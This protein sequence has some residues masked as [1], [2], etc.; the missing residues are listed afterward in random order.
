MHERQSTQEHKYSCLT[1]PQAP[2]AGPGP[3]TRVMIRI[4]TRT[5]TTDQGQ[6]YG[7]DQDQVSWL[8]HQQRY[9]TMAWVWIPGGFLVPHTA[10]LWTYGWELASFWCERTRS[11]EQKN[12]TLTPKSVLLM[13]QLMGVDVPSST[14]NGQT[15]ARTY[16]H[17]HSLRGSV[18]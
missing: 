8:P 7:K 17:T 14:C 2:L 4:Q 9:I 12:Q 10:V 1:Q 3:G 13:Q 15:Y 5:G 11:D 6:D 18:A 16:G